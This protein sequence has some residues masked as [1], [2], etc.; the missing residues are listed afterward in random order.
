M[1]VPRA[2]SQQK[3][4]VTDTNRIMDGGV[5]KTMPVGVLT[6]VILGCTMKKVD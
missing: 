5:I 1:P 4:S 2:F 6:G 3:L